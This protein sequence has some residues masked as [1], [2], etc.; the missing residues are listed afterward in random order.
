M[1]QD[2]NGE[3]RA[4]VVGGD[5]RKCHF[6]IFLS[7]DLMSKTY[8][9]LPLLSILHI[10]LPIQN[11]TPRFLSPIHRMCEYPNLFGGVVVYTLNI[12]S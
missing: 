1:S 3:K 5:Q 10:H 8:A 4:H 12:T 11:D 2:E 7:P 9:G 6:L